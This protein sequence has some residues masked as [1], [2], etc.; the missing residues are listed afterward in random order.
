MSQT[1]QQAKPELSNEEKAEFLK[2]MFST[3]EIDEQAIFAQ[4]CHEQVEQGGIK[5]LGKKI[6]E[7]NAKMNDFI[8]KAYDQVS[9]GAKFVYNKTNEA[10]ETKPENEVKNNSNPTGDGKSSFFD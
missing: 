6:E 10:F 4:W 8:A 9:K 3:L 2:A 7:T 5:F 1:N